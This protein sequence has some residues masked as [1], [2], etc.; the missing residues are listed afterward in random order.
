MSDYETHVGKVRKIKTV[1]GESF[2]DK[3][4]MLYFN[5]GGKGEY[6]DGILFDEFYNKFIRIG[7]EIYKI[8]DNE[9]KECFDSFCELSENGDGTYSFSTMFYNGGTCLSE[10]LAEEIKKIEEKENE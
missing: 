5:S 7:E 10:M 4:K 6:Y 3:C 2:E 9:E 1:M 8:Y